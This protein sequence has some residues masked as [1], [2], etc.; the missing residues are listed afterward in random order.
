MNDKN[1]LDESE[2]V[3][4]SI[5]PNCELCIVNR[6]VIWGSSFQANNDN[7]YSV[8]ERT[9]FQPKKQINFVIWYQLEWN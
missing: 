6:S 4:F 1:N 7:D 8:N 2:T 9:T 3:V 5:H